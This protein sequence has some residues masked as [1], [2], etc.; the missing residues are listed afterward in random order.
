MNENEAEAD[1]PEPVI[2]KELEVM[3]NGA[4][5]VYVES[6][7]HCYR[8]FARWSFHSSPALVSDA[9]PNLLRA[10]RITCSNT[11]RSK[12]SRSSRCRSRIC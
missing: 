3:V 8:A 2:W 7:V 6:K 12:L 9:S 11:S 10:L 4:D 1:E 5:D